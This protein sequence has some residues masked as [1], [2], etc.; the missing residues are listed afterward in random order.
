MNVPTLYIVQA[1][2]RGAWMMLRNAKLTISPVVPLFFS[3]ILSTNSHAIIF[4][5]DKDF[6]PVISFN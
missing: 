2:V 3:T 6:D 1:S 5:I 4:H